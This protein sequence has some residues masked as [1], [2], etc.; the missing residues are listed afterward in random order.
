MAKAVQFHRFAAQYGSERA[1]MWL[2]INLEDF[3]F[4][5][6]NPVTSTLS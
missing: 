1:K 2:E 6:V 4:L 3:P 5:L